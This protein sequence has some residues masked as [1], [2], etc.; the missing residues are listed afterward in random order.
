MADS[1]I[2]RQ[3]A[4]CRLIVTAGCGGV[5]KTTLAAALGITA[6]RAGRR[7][8]IITIDPARRLAQALGLNDGLTHKPQ[9]VPLNDT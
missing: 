1:I 3:I 9:P 7:V 2:N 5:G 8:A 6:A 4:D